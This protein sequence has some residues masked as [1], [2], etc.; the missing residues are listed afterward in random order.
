MIS[1]LVETVTARGE[2]ERERRGEAQ[3]NRR[4][5]RQRSRR[6]SP[7]FQALEAKRK[8]QEQER[9]YHTSRNETITTAIHLSLRRLSAFSSATAASRAAT[10]SVSKSNWMP[11]FCSPMWWA[12]EIVVSGGEKD[13]QDLTKDKREQSGGRRMTRREKGSPQVQSFQAIWHGLPLEDSRQQ[14][15][16]I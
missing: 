14:H 2:R 8:G 3:R 13:G 7:Q 11:L 9:D 15:Y 16:L 5:P 12:G 6:R 10:S 4:H 1:L